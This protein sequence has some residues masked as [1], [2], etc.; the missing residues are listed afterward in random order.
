MV[1]LN[2]VA[3]NLLAAAG[4]VRDRLRR[5]RDRENPPDLRTMAEVAL[6]SLRTRRKFLGDV[7]IRDRQILE[8]GSGQ[9]ACLGLLFLALGA[10]RVANVEI[11][12]YGFVDD[13]RLYRLLARRASRNGIPMAWPPEGLREHTGP[14]EP[15][16]ARLALHLGCSGVAV[17]EDDRTFDV[18]LSLAVLEHVRRDDM[19][20]LARE[21]YRVL[22]PGGISY[23][24]IDLVD[25]YTRRTE[26]FRFLRWSETEYRWMYGHR[27][28]SSNRLRMDDYERIFR[29]AGFRDVRFEDVRRHVNEVEFERWRR[30]FHPD[31]RDRPSS[32]L[33]AHECLLIVRR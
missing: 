2:E 31:F 24:R 16:P 12:R 15:D 17:P 33:R 3:I 8:I 19:P 30:T 5:V 1:H 23:H 22:R 18:V 29:E 25:H 27:G 20:G 7:G 4:P 28:S 6:T 13:P 32:M 21:S 10:K 14:I 11:D 9:N 26:P